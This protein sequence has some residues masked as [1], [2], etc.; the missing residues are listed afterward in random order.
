VAESEQNP[1]PIISIAPAFLEFGRFDSKTPLTDLPS[2]SITIGNSGGSTL[3]GRLIAQVSWL[4]ISPVEFRCQGGQSSIHRVQL[5][6]GTPTPLNLHQ[7]T[8]QNLILITSNGG[9]SALGGTYKIGPGTEKARPDI[10]WKIILIPVLMIGF[11]FLL[12]FGGM[13]IFS[14][15]PTPTP[16]D[17]AMLYTFGAETI[18]AKLTPEATPSGILSQQG[19]G[20][21]FLTQIRSTEATPFLES[22]VTPTFT[23]WIRADFP[24]SEQF[25]RDYFKA[26]NNLDYNRSW[27]MLSTH[28]QQK[29]CDIGGNDPF[30][31]YKSYWSSIQKVEILSV[32]LLDW[33]SNPARLN[34][35]LRYY[36]KNGKT[37]ESLFLYRLISDP[38]K[39]TLFIYEV[40]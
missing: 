40:E 18:I 13:N 28:F 31:V 12:V 27:A 30:N 5:S 32:Y 16:L 11:L 33:N 38:V 29:C 15:T 9:D 6:T 10:P 23:P 25:I 39:K 21:S 34:V 7:Y 3:V 17:M 14:R 2:V 22:V 36:Y 4:I 1:D 26:V 19:T 37:A 24:N 20:N 8:F 35:S